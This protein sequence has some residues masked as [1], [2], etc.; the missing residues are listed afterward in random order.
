MPRP[1]KLEML[2]PAGASAAQPVGMASAAPCAQQLQAARD[3]GYKAGLD[4]AEAAAQADS[5]AAH[6]EILRE[7]QALSFTFHEARAHLAEGLAPLLDA[8]CARVLP[9]AA[10]GALGPL[11]REALMPALEGALDRPVT[12][13]LHPAS[14]SAVEAALAQA[15]PVPVSLIDDPD[16]AP[17]EI[18]IANGEREQRIDLDAAIDRIRAIVRD[19]FAAPIPAAVSPAD[20]HPPPTEEMR[21][22]G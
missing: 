22:H 17:A 1:V 20:D 3:A 16:L 21:R 14:R 11:L 2:D 4:A 15:P 10:Q 5:V 9:E 8:I 7:L 6:R 12:L 19:F 13:R 18:R